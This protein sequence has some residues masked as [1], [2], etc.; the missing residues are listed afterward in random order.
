MVTIRRASTAEDVAT[1]RSLVEEYAAALAFGLEFQDFEQELEGF[2]GEY[3]PP[4]GAILLA[5]LGG[6]ALGCVCL[7]RL[8]HGV[9]EMK[10]LYVRPSGRGSGAGRALAEALLEEGRR[11]GYARM[12]LDTVEAMKAAN[13]LYRSLGFREIEPYRA[14]P[15]EGATFFERDL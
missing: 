8:S 14:N 9:C 11:L 3:G 12:R 4:A 2:P 13:A 7:R 10:R 5:E 6:E 15:I 1:A